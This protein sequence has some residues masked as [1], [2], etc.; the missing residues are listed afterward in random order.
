MAWL[1]LSRAGAKRVSVEQ[2]SLQPA[3]PVV[4]EESLYAVEKSGP[5][6]MISKR[7]CRCSGEAIYRPHK[8]A[9]RSGCVTQLND[10]LPTPR[11]ASRMTPLGR[12]GEFAGFRC[13]HSARDVEGAQI[14]IA[15][16]PREPVANS[17]TISQRQLSVWTCRSAR[18]P[19]A[20]SYRP[21]PTCSRA[22]RTAAVS[23]DPP[24]PAR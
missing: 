13:S 6:I 1:P 16:R 5:E 24:A 4:P 7:N 21:P 18:K 20:G 9:R 23:L 19:L 15:V 22:I 14:V 17:T 11:F 3:I 8:Q 2:E 12:E 10:R